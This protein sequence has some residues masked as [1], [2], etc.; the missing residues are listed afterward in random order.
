MHTQ[1]NHSTKVTCNCFGADGPGLCCSDGMDV[2]VLSPDAMGFLSDGHLGRE[3]SVENLISENRLQ[4][5][6]MLSALAWK[7]PLVL[8]AN[9]RCKGAVFQRGMVL[10]V[11]YCRTV[12]TGRGPTKGR[13]SP[14]PTLTQNV[15]T[16]FQPCAD[17]KS[18]RLSGCSYSYVFT[19]FL[20]FWAV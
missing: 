13:H 8:E 16:H 19:S 11:N 15:S 20:L 17:R 12:D 9:M 3:G 5:G 4:T 10:H 1:C 14:H 2:V 7:W 6:F 18:P